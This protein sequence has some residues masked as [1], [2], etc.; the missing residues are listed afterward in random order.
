MIDD[1]T[2]FVA[3]ECSFVLCSQFGCF[4]RC[5]RFGCWRRIRRGWG[6]IATQMVSSF[7]TQYF[8]IPRFDNAKLVSRNRRGG[9]V[10]KHPPHECLSGGFFMEFPQLMYGGKKEERDRYG[11]QKQK[12]IRA[13]HTCTFPPSDIH[14][15]K[16][17]G[18]TISS[19][20]LSP[21]PFFFD[22]FLFPIYSTAVCTYEKDDFVE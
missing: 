2:I 7:L 6:I 14:E 11:V 1:Y 4:C 21:S 10:E 22:L 5:W 20:S 13:F 17:G 12:I 9:Y 3:R 18:N 15:F 16:F 19:S 8:F